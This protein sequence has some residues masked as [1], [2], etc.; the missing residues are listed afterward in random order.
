MLSDITLE[1]RPT[2][3]DRGV[4][5]KPWGRAAMGWAAAPSFRGSNHPC[6][7]HFADTG[8]PPGWLA[9]V[10]SNKALVHRKT[11]EK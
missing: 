11:A 8:R 6:L 7:S 3:A 2:I 10:F 4:P 1:R 9:S 5:R